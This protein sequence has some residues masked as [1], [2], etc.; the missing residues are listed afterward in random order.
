MRLILVTALICAF[1]SGLW[2]EAAANPLA[3]YTF[4]DQKARSLANFDSQ[5]VAVWGMCKS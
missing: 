2:A 1:S 3:E 5:T 4:A